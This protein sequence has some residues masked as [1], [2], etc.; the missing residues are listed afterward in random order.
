MSGEQVDPVRDSMHPAS[1]LVRQV[2]A[3]NETMEFIMR[4]EMEINET[5]FQAMQHLLKLR[6]VSPSELSQMLHLTPAATTTVIDRLVAKGHVHRS[7]HPTDRRRW[8]ISP[9]DESVQSA[10]EMLMP[11]ILDVD[12]AVRGYEE[13]EQR[14]IVDFLSGVVDSM[15]G[16]ITSLESE[17]EMKYDH[18]HRG[19]VKGEQ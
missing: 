1:A 10:M 13:H 5:D 16:R 6:S 8:V 18:L 11:M 7:P 17:I 4:R 14:V 15:T 9:S 12:Q 2:L 19:T 3:L